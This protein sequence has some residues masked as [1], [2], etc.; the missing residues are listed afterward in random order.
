MADDEFNNQLKKAFQELQTQ[1]IECR[2]KQKNAEVTKNA[3]KQNIRIANIVKNQLEIIPPERE[4]YRTVGR[5]FLQESVQSEIERQNADV[6]QCEERIAIIDK[7]KEYL[8]KNVSEKE[9][10]LREMIKSSRNAS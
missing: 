1:L 4:V 8:E 10:N 9:N 7:Q 3:M 6:K 5:I 2:E